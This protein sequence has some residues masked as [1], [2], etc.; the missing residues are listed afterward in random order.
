MTRT[1]SAL[2]TENYLK[3]IVKALAE[4]G[5]ER[6]STGELARL[7]G[8]TAGTATSMVK[9]LE[10]DG[11]VSNEAR[12]GCILTKAGR[13]YGLRILRR[14]RLLESFL[15]GVLHMDWADVHEEAENLEHAVSERL[16]DAIDAF[17]GNP[18]RDP[19]G[20]PIPS[21]IQRVYAVRD[22]PLSALDEGIDVT[23]V[24][25]AGDRTALEYFRREGLVPGAEVRVISRQRDAGLA[26]LSVA[27]REAIFAMSTLGRVFFEAPH[28]ERAS[29]HAD[30]DGARNA[31]QGDGAGGGV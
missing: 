21:K 19:H 25:V 17:M 29:G 11:Y 14:H 3:A 4:P 12:Q 24:R 7:L 2:A 28:A 23:I 1:P 31:V 15:V 6:L 10:K 20:D 8:V 26:T 27:G 30:G 22:T 18:R 13:A 9:K 5:R 16:V